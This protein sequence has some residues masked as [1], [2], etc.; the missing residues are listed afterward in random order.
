MDNLQEA[1]ISTI[2]ELKLIQS[3]E[4]IDR[5][6]EFINDKDLGVRLSAVE[7]LSHFSKSTKVKHMLLNLASDTNSEIRYNAVES[8]INFPEQEVFS[9]LTKR[10]TDNNELVRIVTVEVLGENYLELAIPHLI[11]LLSDKASLVRSYVAET[12]GKSGDKRLIPLFKKA[13]QQEKRNIARL[14]FYIGLYLLG[15]SSCLKSILSL[16]KTRSY[17]V[18]CAVANSLESLSTKEN[19]NL[20]MEHLNLALSKEQTVAAK[21]SITNAIQG[22]SKKFN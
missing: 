22:I 21:S 4:A 12:L 16:L 18:R 15:E 14:G 13:L 19:Y 20:I 17:R 3:E 6:I 11:P 9:S 7:A 10:L 8:L 1:K 2:N 5:I